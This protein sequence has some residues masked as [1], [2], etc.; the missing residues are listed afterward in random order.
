VAQEFDASALAEVRVVLYD[1]VR[2]NMLTSRAVLHGIGFRSI[3]GIT[4]FDELSSRLRDKE[5]ALCLLEAG[6]QVRD[7]CD[8][9]RRLRHGDLGGNP[10]LPVI[11]TLWHAEGASVADLMRAGFDDVLVR[12]FSVQ[13]AQERVRSLIAARKPFVVTSDYVG[14]DRGPQGPGRAS[15]EAVEVP[16]ILRLLARREQTNLLLIQEEVVRAGEAVQ[17][18]R[19]A[20]LARRIAMAAEVTIQAFSDGSNEKSFILDLLDSVDRLVRAAR[21]LDNDEVIDIADVLESVAGRIASNGADRANDAQLTRQLALALF[22]AYA[23]DTGE[24]FHAELDMAL[25]SVRLRLDKAKA[26]RKRR[27]ELSSLLA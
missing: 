12:P 23:A 15:A 9:V 14:P 11:S 27:N 5:V 22:V 25:E 2:A 8:L 10:F 7:C 18:Q 21:L 17:K 16:N 1:P 3:E 6:D 13:K 20:K 26:R 19:L 24:S 4:E